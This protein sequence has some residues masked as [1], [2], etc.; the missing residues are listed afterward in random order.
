MQVTDEQ[1]LITNVKNCA[2]SESLN[3]LIAKHS[4]ICYKIFTKFIPSVEKKGKDFKDLTNNKDYFIYKAAISF[5]PDKNARFSTWLGNYVRYKCLD[6][7]NETEFSTNFESQ[8]S[9][10]SLNSMSKNKFE[11]SKDLL[12]RKEMVFDT[13]SQLKDKRIVSVYRLRYFTTH[14]KMSWKTIG[15]KV[16]VSTQTTIN[17]HEKGRKAVRGKIYKKIA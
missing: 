13:L 1:Q 11:E 2:C 17:L 5:N 15:E 9:Q 6:F 12:D 7:L 16:G 10:S 3:H 14:P 4:G 8:E